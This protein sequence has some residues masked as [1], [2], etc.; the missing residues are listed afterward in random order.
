MVVS[1]P[2]YG[3]S[4]EVTIIE[5]TCCGF[6]VGGGEFGCAGSP[7]GL[8]TCA[9]EAIVGSCDWPRATNVVGN[10]TVSLSRPCWYGFGDA[11][12]LRPAPLLGLGVKGGEGECCCYR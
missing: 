2:R 9:G 8:F 4:I 11:H 12:V 1:V 7:C 3:G 6:T 5:R 10:V